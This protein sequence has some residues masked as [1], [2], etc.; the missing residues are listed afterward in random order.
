MVNYLTDKNLREK[1]NRMRLSVALCF[2]LALLVTI[3]SS[4]EAF[5]LPRTSRHPIAV[6]RYVHKLIKMSIHQARRERRQSFS[7]AC[8]SDAMEASRD[9]FASCEVSK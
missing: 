6:T 1:K 3:F 9:P 4:S 5:K 8:I 7:P 2:F